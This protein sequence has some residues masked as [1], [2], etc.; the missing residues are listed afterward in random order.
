MNIA[1]VI[2]L[3]GRDDPKV[4][5]LHLVRN[6]LCDERNG[7]WLLILDSADD[8]SVLSST[9]AESHSLACG[10]NTA[11]PSMDTFLPQ[12]ANGWILV[13]SRDR[14]AAQN[15]VQSSN[16]IDVGPMP[17]NDSLLLLKNKVS[18]AE[19]FGEDAKTLVRT[20]EYI[21]L[22]VSHA[23]VYL[24]V[25]AQTMDIS[26]YLLLFHESKENQAKLL[27]HEDFR[28][29]RR[30][31]SLSHDPISTWQISFEQI[32]KT[33][34]DA[35][36][37]LSLMAMFDRQ[38]I[39]EAI[40][41]D[42]RRNQQFEEALSPLTRFSLIKVVGTTKK[43]H[44]VDERLFEMHDLVQLATRD[45]LE[46]Q[47]QGAKWRKASLRIMAAA[48]PTGE[49][50]TWANCRAL[51]PHAQKVIAYDLEEREPRLDRARIAHNT[52]AYLLRVGEYAAA[53]E[54]GRTA[55]VIKEKTLGPEHP[56]TL[57][58]VDN[59]GLVV[60]RQGKYEEAEAM[61][62]RALKEREKVLGVEHPCTFASITNLGSVLMRQGKYEEAEAMHR[63][64]LEV[65]DVLGVEDPNTLASVFSNLGSSLERQ[66]KCEEAE[67]TYRRTLQIMEVLGIED[68]H[69]LAN[70]VSNLGSSLKRQGKY[71]EAETMYRRALEIMEVLGVEHPNTLA[72]VFNNLGSLLEHQ[73]KD[74]E[75]E[76]MYRREQEIMSVFGVDQSVMLNSANKL[77]SVPASQEGT[78][79]RK[80]CI[81]KT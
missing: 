66:G 6:W 53:E 35:A 79:K 11:S 71:E 59:L 4:D 42:D 34:P 68:P 55:V 39:P 22:A 13:T 73:G 26:R 16:V 77:G 31:H 28:D 61:H 38:A 25:R 58:S 45:W 74:E 65:M 21:P 9:N 54:I 24:T 27:S 80:R 76:T 48:Y 75:A 47:G 69:R 23:A 70:V 56:D 36:E 14:L 64:A 46:K 50:E 41:S 17:E 29:M 67:T 62:R 60:E 12:S 37:L 1:S 63:R 43:E 78:K 10:T 81:D 40:V 19:A 18:V 7:R 57:T 2:E 32:R 52:S 72:S 5:I 30:D 15:L 49:H 51:L 8:D 3:P 44:Q 20:L 33:T